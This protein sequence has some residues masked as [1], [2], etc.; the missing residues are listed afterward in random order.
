[1]V[2]FFIY[3]FIDDFDF[4]TYNPSVGKNSRSGSMKYYIHIISF[5]RKLVRKQT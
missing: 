5:Y 4:G 2:I 3:K 1:M